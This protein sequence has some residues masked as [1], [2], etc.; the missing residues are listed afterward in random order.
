MQTNI[1]TVE[2]WNNRVKTAGNEKDMIFCDP[3]REKFWDAVRSQIGQWKDLDSLEVC[4]GYGQFTMKEGGD[5][6]PEMLTLA[7]NKYPELTFFELNTKVGN[8]REYQLIYEVNSLHS[9]GWTP[10]QFHEKYKGK[11]QII[12]CLEADKFTIFYDYR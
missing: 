10:E 8:T 6:C 4:C 7:R 11:A 12:A 2:Y 3:R 5:F 9:L 1:G